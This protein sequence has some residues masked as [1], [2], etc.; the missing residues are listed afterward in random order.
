MVGNDRKMKQTV[1][2]DR[3]AAIEATKHEMKALQQ[4]L[5]RNK[6]EEKG[7]KDAA[8]KAKKAWNQAQKEYAALN[9]NIKKMASVLDDLKAEADTSEEVPTIDTSEYES[10]IQEAEAIVEDLKRREA[11]VVQEIESLQPG[12]DDQ[13]KRL[14]EITA[15]NE[16]I[17]DDLDKV[18]SKLEDIVKGQTRR[19]DQVDKFRAKVDQIEQG[20]AEQEEVV[21]GAKEKV[22]TA[23][24]KARRMQFAANRDRKKFELKQE[25]GGVA[26]DEEMALDPTD[27][28]LEEI[29]V[30]DPPKDSK[31]Y[32]AKVVNK[33]K[34]IAQEKDRRNLSESDP[35]VARDK[36]FRAKKDLDSK[37][38]QINAID[39]NV[40]ALKK[41]LKERKKR[42][43]DFRA[44]IAEMTNLSFDEFLNKKGSAGEVQFDHEDRKLDL[45]VQKVCLV[46]NCYCA[47]C[48]YQFL[49]IFL[50]PKNSS[51]SPR[52][53]PMNT[54]RP[55][56]SRP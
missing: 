30:I 56:T 6:D 18:D 5:A 46:F 21:S 2:V 19:Q 16:K 24:E 12:L 32:K 48:T 13:R 44:H 53:M 37:M 11:A 28:D 27:D 51:P 3:S 8:F 47:S 25:N 42:W 43:R 35:A 31:F 54:L 52:T 34:K 50:T 9:T 45:V 15:R 14:E 33:E 1:G 10:D 29:E 55:R 38:E 40:K 49:V 41:D 17:L 22:S 39:R 7:V 36:Y 26:P 23:L 4:E 20:L